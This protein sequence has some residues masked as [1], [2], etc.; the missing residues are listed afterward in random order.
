MRCPRDV[1]ET[2]ATSEK[3][4]ETALVQLFVVKQQRFQTY[5]CIITESVQ[6]ESTKSVSLPVSQP[7]IQ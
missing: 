4:P 1:S 5:L 7:V 3:P 2:R 6:S